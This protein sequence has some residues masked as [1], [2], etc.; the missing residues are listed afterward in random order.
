MNE[1]GIKYNLSTRLSRTG[2]FKDQLNVFS[3]IDFLLRSEIIIP[4][5]V[6][7]FLLPLFPSLVWHCALHK[8]KMCSFILVHTSLCSAKE[9]AESSVSENVSTGSSSKRRCFFCSLSLTLFNMQN[10]HLF[11]PQVQGFTLIGNV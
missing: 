6:Y 11:I 5:H 10:K 1:N 3:V 7:S 2:H 4:R 9:S 8:K